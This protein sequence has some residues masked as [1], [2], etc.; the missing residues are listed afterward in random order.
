MC[1]LSV[2]ILYLC[3]FVLT[4]AI[5]EEVMEVKKAAIVH[6]ARGE[7]EIL[8]WPIVPGSIF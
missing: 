8:C 7:C 1:L 2:L 3:V 6:S 5:V 4:L